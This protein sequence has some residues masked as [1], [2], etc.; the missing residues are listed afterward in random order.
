MTDAAIVMRSATFRYGEREALHDLSFQVAVGTI[1]S[2]VGPNGA[3]KTTMMKLLL[4]LIRPAEGSAQVLGFDVSSEGQ[5]IRERSAALLE[6]TGL[7]DRLSGETNLEFYARVWRLTPDQRNRR[8]RDVLMHFGLWQRRRDLVGTWS[9]GMK[10]K[11]AIARALL[12]KPAL[13]LLD[14][15]TAGLDPVAA[16]GLRE[17][18]AGLAEREGMT[19]FMSTHNLREVEEMADQ[20]VVLR[21]GRIVAAG[22]P[23]AIARATGSPRTVTVV[24]AGLTQPVADALSQLPEVVSIARVSDGLTMQIAAGAGLSSIIQA[25]TAAGVQIHDVRSTHSELESAFLKLME[26]R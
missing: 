6:H 7:Y 10:Q 19:V 22:S 25:L 17:L 21:E 18:V 11:L 13:L 1:F 20:I 23:A 5:Q 14:E 26:E 3:G 16:A 9:R 8:I 2:V 4:G 24:A 12:H 15:P